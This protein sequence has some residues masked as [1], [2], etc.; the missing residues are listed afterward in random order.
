MSWGVWGA[1]LTALIGA[2]GYA[3]K[4][5]TDWKVDKLLAGQLEVLRKRH[6]ARFDSIVKTQGMPA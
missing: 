1:I 6:V 4:K 5:Y 2:L 3:L